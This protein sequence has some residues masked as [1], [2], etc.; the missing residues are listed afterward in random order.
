MTNGTRLTV[1]N[2]TT[3]SVSFLGGGASIDTHGL[4]S[5]T[6]PGAGLV[7]RVGGPLDH[8][9]PGAGRS[10]MLRRSQVTRP[11]VEFG[12]EF[13][14]DDHNRWFGHV[15]QIGDDPERGMVLLRCP[16]CGA[17]YENTMVG[18]D[19]TRRLSLQQARQLYGRLPG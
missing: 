15:P 12:C 7:D 16:R 11:T 4:L 8:L 5:V 19:R 14:A 13:C 18:S 10:L 6:R 2:L 1:T 17:V 3:W 9:R